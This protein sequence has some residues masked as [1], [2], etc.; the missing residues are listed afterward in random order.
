MR[1]QGFPWA[2]CLIA[3]ICIGMGLVALLLAM[4]AVRAP[5][6]PGPAPLRAGDVAVL[7]GKPSWG[8]TTADAFDAVL[9]AID[10][11]DDIRLHE[12]MADRRFRTL[13]I[14]VRVKLVTSPNKSKS[15][16]PTLVELLAGSLAGERFIVPGYTLA[17]VP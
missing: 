7:I 9:S 10:K 13:E 14:G 17:P 15:G 16:Q 2:G 5:S 12:A 3:A 4:V 1:R 11:D 6:Q 8:T